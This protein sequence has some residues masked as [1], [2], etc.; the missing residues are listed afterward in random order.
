MSRTHICRQ[1]EEPNVLQHCGCHLQRMRASQVVKPDTH[2]P[3]RIPHIVQIVDNDLDKDISLDRV[4]RG[5]LFEG[6]LVASEE[7]YRRWLVRFQA[8]VRPEKSVRVVKEK[9][10]LIISVTPYNDLHVRKRVLFG[11]PRSEH[12]D[13]LIS[14]VNSWEQEV[15]LSFNDRVKK[16]SA[17]FLKWK[18]EP[19][20]TNDPIL[21]QHLKVVSYVDAPIHRADLV[22][23]TSRFRDMNIKQSRA[24][25]AL[26]Q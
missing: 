1:H 19:E 25:K 4:L 2:R 22:A 16:A 3:G 9:P 10:S 12:L 11:A 13:A 21:D 18:E 8:G 15:L 23:F 20:V 26:Q 24:Q 6:H 7:N 5:E 17:R 14:E